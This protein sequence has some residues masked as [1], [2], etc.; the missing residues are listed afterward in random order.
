MKILY[1]PPISFNDLKQRPQYLAEELSKKH[2]ILYVDPTVSIMKFLLRG[3]EKPF[4]YRYRVNDHLEVLR[5]N[6]MLSLHRCMESVWKGISLWERFQIHKLIKNIDAVWVGYCPWFNLISN[7]NGIVIYDKMDDD[8]QITQNSMLKK[9]IL[10]VEPKLIRRA[11]HV[12]VSAQVF[13]DRIEKSGKK[14]VL[15]P[16]AVEI[17]HKKGIP[18]KKWAA[19]YRIYGYVG[20]VSHWFDMDAIKEILNIDQ[21]NYV[22]LVGPTE[23]PQFEHERLEYVGRVPKDEVGNWIASFDVCLY[24]FKKNTFLDTIN[25]VKIYEY[26]A[27]NKPIL[28]VRS[29]E[30][31]KIHANIALYENF[32]QL[33]ILLISNLKLP[34]YSEEEAN[35]FR[36]GNNWK[37]RAKQILEE[38]EYG[39]P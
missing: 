16:N 32:E 7:F 36:V 5:M 6:G 34:F 11:D 31:E 13:K 26:L 22:V 3:G 30:T 38:I 12:F 35:S 21:N 17:Q 19:H 39:N 28:A 10:E 27:Q 4:G 14:A 33:R 8:I 18:A 29:K 37:Y 9:L 24:P 2:D 1:F 25:P 23:I 20:M 15:V